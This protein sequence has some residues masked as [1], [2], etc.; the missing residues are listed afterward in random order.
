MF[1][2]PTNLLNGG[3]LLRPLLLNYLRVWTLRWPGGDGLTEDDVL[4]S[5]PQAIADEAIPCCQE[6]CRQ[7]PELTTEIRS[8][9]AHSPNAISEK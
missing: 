4:N 9:F 2:G 7:H 8:F 5:V 3:L 1:E 6:F